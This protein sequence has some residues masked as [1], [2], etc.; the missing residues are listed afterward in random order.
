M[1]QPRWAAAQAPPPWALNASRSAVIFLTGLG[2]STLPLCLGTGQSSALELG[3]AFSGGVFIAAG[4]CHLL[5]DATEALSDAMGIDYP[6][7][8]LLCSLGMLAMLIIDQLTTRAIAKRG[9]APAPVRLSDEDE[10]EPADH[11]PGEEVVP[12][13]SS[14][15]IPS[16]ILFSALSFHSLMAGLSLGVSDQTAWAIFI[17][18]LAHKAFA[19]FA[20]GAS[21]VRHLAVS[22]RTIAC[23]MLAF[24]VT[25]PTG[26]M[27]GTA[28]TTVAENAL[29]G[30]LTAV[31][32]GTFLHVG[33]IEVAQRELA[34][35]EHVCGSMLM[36]L[37]GFS[38]MALLA[39][40]V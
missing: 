6:V 15:L 16:I 3:V 17:S 31:A 39:L 20:L 19:A 27:L 32:A 11:A 2:G 30:A 5:P 9:T 25:T 4:F 29:T 14:G 23:W 10:A 24:S 13:L 37:L 26:V 21:F 36:L 1:S 18:I 35:A 28:L 33:L 40:W 34:K 22:R 38:L 8:P 7:A 12:L